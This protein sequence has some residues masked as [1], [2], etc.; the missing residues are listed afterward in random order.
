MDWRKSLKNYFTIT[1]GRT[2]SAWLTSFLSSNLQINAV[3]EPLGIDD[4]GVNM[5]DIRTM[6]SFNNYGN[7]DFV[8]E[9]WKRKFSNLPNATYAETNHTLCKCGLVEN[10]LLNKLEDETILIVLKRNIVKQCVSYIVRHDFGNITLAWQWYLHPT[11]RKKI[12]NPEPFMKLG[13]I[14]IPLWYCYEM[15]ARQEYYVQKF[16]DKISMNQVTLEELTSDTGAQDFH[17]LLGLHGKCVVPS[18]KNENK[19][20]PNEHLVQQVTD[21]VDKINVDMPQLIEDTIKKGFSFDAV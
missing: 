16:S 9:F 21:F 5:P 10:L 7:N 18:P 2:G 1:A 3:H 14:G 13:G 8:K 20:K 17:D 11:Y 15:S 4:F 12:I 6:R 19:V